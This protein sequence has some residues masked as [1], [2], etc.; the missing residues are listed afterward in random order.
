LQLASSIEKQIGALGFKDAAFQELLKAK[1][2]RI[3]IVTLTGGVENDDI[4]LLGVDRLYA[5][6]RSLCPGDN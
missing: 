4:S 6:M 3:E 5:K 2:L 1:R